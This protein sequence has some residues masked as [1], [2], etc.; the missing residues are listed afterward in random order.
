MIG[1]EITGW[2][3][4]AEAD[5]AFAHGGVLRKTGGNTRHCAVRGLNIVGDCCAG[6]LLGKQGAVEASAIIGH[7]QGGKVGGWVNPVREHEA[8]EAIRI[9][10]LRSYGNGL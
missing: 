8:G 7:A 4:F 1:T 10:E 5:D 3:W 6:R 2:L 9:I